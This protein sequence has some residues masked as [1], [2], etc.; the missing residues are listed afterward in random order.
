MSASRMRFFWAVWRS[1]PESSCDRAEAHAAH[2]TVTS[3]KMI[4]I[5]KNV[6]NKNTPGNREGEEWLRNN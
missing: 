5:D 1:G 3:G 2:G 4:T 6:V